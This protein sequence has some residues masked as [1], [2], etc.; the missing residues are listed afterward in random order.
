MQ[1]LAT[2]TTVKLAIE[3]NI[4]SMKVIEARYDLNQTILAIKENIEAR[5][6]SLVP[7]MRLQLKDQK[8]NLVA[9]LDDDQR[10]LGFYGAATGMILFVN[11]LNPGSIHKEIES[12][13][14]V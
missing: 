5:Y 11:D 7:Y 12:F 8:G 2:N 6:G 1:P 3:H 4:S 13:E 9:D 14:G 10:P